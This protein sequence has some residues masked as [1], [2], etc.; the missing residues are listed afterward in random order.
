[1][2]LCEAPGAFVCALNHW[3]RDKVSPAV[4]WDWR[5]SSLNPWFEGN[6]LRDMID[7]DKLLHDTR[8]RWLFGAD[9]SGNICR[10]ANV[11][12]LWAEAATFG[13]VQLVTADG[14]VFS[15]VRTS[16]SWA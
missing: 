14:A 3:L 6:S 13:P 15:Q 8:E 9:G 5:A 7:D 12:A 11:R 4:D 10:A 2:H 16:H 1:M